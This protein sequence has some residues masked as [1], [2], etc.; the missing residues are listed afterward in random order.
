MNQQAYDQGFDPA[1]YVGSLRNYRSFV[2][3]LM[4]TAVADPGHVERLKQAAARLPQ[5]V[6]ATVMTEDWCGDSACNLPILANLF[7]R[8]GVELRLLRGSEHPELKRYYEESGDDHIPVLS[9]WDGDW[10]EAAR[11]IEAPEAAEARKD[12]WKAARPAFMDAYRRKQTGDAEAAK[13]FAPMY[14]E[15]LDEMSGWYR[16]GLWTETTREVAER[17]ERGP[18]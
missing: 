17:L 10:A 9:I 15:L 3:G 1:A 13:Q 7:A 6:R 8:A 12:A 16:D 4:E 11:W 18:A 14:R 5:P 2:K